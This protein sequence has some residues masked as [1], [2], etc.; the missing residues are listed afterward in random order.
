MLLA[1]TQNN[2]MGLQAIIIAMQSMLAVNREAPVTNYLIFSCMS[3]WMVK[4][5]QYYEW[6]HHGKQTH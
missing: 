6:S 3:V 4:L 1:E 5:L 2:I